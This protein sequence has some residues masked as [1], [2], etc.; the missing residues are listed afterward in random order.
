MADR[1]PAHAVAIA[2]YTPQF[3][4]KEVISTFF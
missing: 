1:R 3:V 2:Q 4:D